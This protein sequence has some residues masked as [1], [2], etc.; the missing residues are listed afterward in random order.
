MKRLYWLIF[1]V[2]LK[3]EAQTSALTI[4]DSLFQ[5]GNY[6]KAIELYQSAPSSAKSIV[7]KNK[8]AKAYIGLGAYT[9][10]IPYYESVMQQD[11]MQLITAY[12]LG[13]IYYKTKRFENASTTFNWLTK[14]DS[15]NP[16]FYYQLGLTQLQ[17]K[18]RDYI[19]TLKKGFNTDRK[20]LKLIQQLSKYYL[21]KS[22]WKNFNRYTNIGLQHYPENQTLIN[23]KA[24]SC[25][26][27]QLYQQA[28]TYF[29]KL[30]DIDPYNE[31]VVYKL[32]L[33]HHHLLDYKKAVDYYNEVLIIDN[34]N[35][36]YHTKIGLAYMGMENYQQSLI[37][38]YMAFQMN[39]VALDDEL[40]NLGILFKEQRKYKMAIS[41]FKKAIAENNT[42][43][44]AHFQLA[45]CADNFYEDKTTKL[46]YYENY[47]RDF[48]G[49]KPA[50]DKIV[51]SRISH[52]KTELHLEN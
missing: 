1:I 50:Y 25:F 2:V 13:K 43:H 31:F 12:E 5:L 41:Y 8:I 26:N 11:S 17:L 32:G 42:N 9:K 27:Q 45:V 49:R 7:L 3:A 33:C 34:S 20:H 36:D 22:D 35:P 4:A 37:H 44:N 18:N 19:I 15:L 24:Q 29:T 28:I 39:S 23:Y 47:K 30:Y 38:L 16:N 46:Q 6:N 14:K 21:K 51:K 10:A 52:Y 48:E 40:Y